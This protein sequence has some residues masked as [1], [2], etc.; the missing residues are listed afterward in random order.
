MLQPEEIPEPYVIGCAYD[1]IVINPQEYIPWLKSQLIHHGV[2]LV[3]KQVTTLEELTPFVDSDGILVN[4]SGLGE[5]DGPAMVSYVT[6]VSSRFQVDYWHRGY[7]II[8]NTWTN[9][10]RP[11]I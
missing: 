4:A 7:Q 8:S 3:R 5:P 11:V 2:Q 6:N 1:T 10:S 9:D